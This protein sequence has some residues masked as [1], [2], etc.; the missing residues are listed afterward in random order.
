MPRLSIRALAFV[1]LALPAGPAWSHAARF[2]GPALHGEHRVGLGNV[3][4]SKFG[5][6]IFGF[7][8]DRHGSDGILTEA[9]SFGSATETFDIDTGKLTGVIDKLESP[10]QDDELVTLGI[11]ANDVGFIDEERLTVISGKFTRHDR[12]LVVNPVTG[13]KVTSQWNPPHRDD[14]L[15]WSV[16]ENQETSTQAVF[17]YSP[18]PQPS[19]LEIP[20]IYVANFASD[21]SARI[22]LDSNLFG[23]GNIPQ[24]AQ[25][26]VTNDAVFALSPDGGRV[27][28]EA[29]LTILVDLATGKQ[30]RY[31]GLNE[32]PFGSGDVN[33]LAVDSASGVA[34]TTTELNAQVEFYTLANGNG[35]A[36][37]LPKTGNTSQENSGATVASDPVHGLFLVTQPFSSTSA[38][39]SVDVYDES[40]NLVET[41]NGFNFG[42]PPGLALNPAKRIG[43][44]SGPAVNELQQFFY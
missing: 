18:P 41:I 14:L 7:D 13:G 33:G 4:A 39:S 16:A 20:W 38:G 2:A 44:I 32:G 30:K 29:P 31:T 25:D 21:Q 6:Q 3:L 34:C 10:S 8:V 24:F 19:E 1:V 42:N 27:G 36:V 23:V 9:P 5:G 26:S 28:G 12:Y 43:W 22:R 17:A 40:G 37:Q 15:L 35:T 11:F